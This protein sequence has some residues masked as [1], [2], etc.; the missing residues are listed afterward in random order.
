MGYEL[1]SPQEATL[2]CAQTPEAPLQVGA[3]CFFEAGPLLDSDGRVR[4]DDLRLRVERR[5]GHVPRFRQVLSMPPLGLGRP[6][7]VD[8][9]RFDVAHHVRGAALPAPGGHRELRAF[10]QRL[11][12]TPLDPS[13]PLWELWVVE[14]L[15]GG[16]VA[17]VPKISHVVA[18]GMAVLAFA[19][20][21]LDTQPQPDAAPDRADAPWEADPPPR[22]LERLAREVVDEVRHGVGAA[23]AVLTALARPGR[24]AAGAAHTAAAARSIVA[25]APRTAMAAPVGPHRDF[26]WASLELSD[27]RAR[28]RRQGATV[29][30]VVLA[31]VA[32]A[33]SDRAA[34]E[35]PARGASKRV[36]VIVPVS[37]HAPGDASG[38]RFSFMVAT[39]PTGPMTAAARLDAVHAELARC[40]ASD[41]TAIA[42]LLFEIGGAVPAPALRWAARVIL[43]RQ[44]LVD[45]AV[46]NLAGAPVPLY[47]MGARMLAAHP[48]I[49]PT[50]NIGVIVGVMSSDQRLD[51][52]VT[53]DADT[54]PDPEQL[55]RAI[56][57]SARKATSTRR[58]RT[59]RR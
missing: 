7:W 58:A 20:A 22:Q 45:L 11:L 1:L 25:R 8:D 56:E 26:A 2:L 42:P 27:V 39:L 51:V 18:D 54:V 9:P 44:P 48:F 47:L 43:R 16:R 17:V 34:G 37:T 30:D 21:M 28:A 53:V 10:V 38:N 52:G 32:S 50:G 5:L 49:T 35:A 3:L 31:L 4:I 12:E 24:F 40:K 36:R 33:L 19:L 46:S 55:A 13:R 14:G 41:Q 15:E 6:A 59:T 23:T 57:R 29:N